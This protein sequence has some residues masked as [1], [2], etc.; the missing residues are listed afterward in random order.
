MPA[1]FV[2]WLVVLGLISLVWFTRHL[3]IS[4]ANAERRALTPTS[5]PGPPEPPPCV[6]VLVAAKD[7]EE[8]IEAC[9]TSFME[10]DYPDFELIVIDD[11]SSDRTPEI[12]NRLKSRYGERLKVLT[13]KRLRDGW[14]GKNNAMGEGVGAAD[15]DWLCFADADCRQTSPATLSMAMSEALSH[16]TDFL[17]VL[18]VLEARS[19]WERIIQPVCAAVMIYWYHPDRVNNPKHPA[20]YA[21]GAF[22][23]IKRQVYDAIGGHERVRTEINEDMHLARLAKGMGFALR[24]TPQ[25]DLYLTRMYASLGQSWRGWSRIFYGCLGSFRRIAVALTI[26]T[27]FSLLPWVSLV[28]SVVGLATVSPAGP[29]RWVAL[30]A[31]AT[32]ALQQSVM[33]RFYRLSRSD[34]RWSALYIVGAVFCFGTL[35]SAMLKLRGATRVTWRG[36]TYRGHRLDRAA[37]PPLTTAADAPAAEEVSAHVP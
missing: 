32:V 13:V 7:E 34:P 5:Y 23:L 36:T 14:F 18:P 25:E 15:G 20:A 28:A 21:N 12:L 35:V 27:T 31:A 4:R 24:V 11:R 22:M 3:A 17:S 1:F 37:R 16:G 33:A 6:S 19:F 10:Q 29:W 26:L 30:A 2:T 8:N 9:V